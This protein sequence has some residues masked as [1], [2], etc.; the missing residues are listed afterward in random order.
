MRGEYLLIQFIVLLII[1]PLYVFHK[2]DFSKKKAFLKTVLVTV[3]IL[4]I[5]EYIALSRGH[6]GYGKEFIVGFI[7]IYP[8]EQFVFYCFISFFAI[9]LW[10]SGKKITAKWG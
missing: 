10:T 5:W 2:L 7:G 6:W 9:T 4:G 3:I 1:I 8:V